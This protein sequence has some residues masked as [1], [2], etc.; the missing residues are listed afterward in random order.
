[1]ADASVADPKV[2]ILVEGQRGKGVFEEVWMGEE[3][4]GGSLNKSFVEDE[5]GYQKSQIE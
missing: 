5:P 2:P 1:M 4:P 3:P